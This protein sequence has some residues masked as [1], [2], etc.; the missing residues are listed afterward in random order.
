MVATVWVEQSPKLP[1]NPLLPRT[2]RIRQYNR[3]RI[4]MAED[5]RIRQRRQRRCRPRARQWAQHSPSTATTTP[6]RQRSTP[7]MRTMPVHRSTNS[8]AATMRHR[9]RISIRKHRRHRAHLPPICPRPPTLLRP[10]RPA[11]SQTP[12]SSSSSHLNHTRNHPQLLPPGSTSLLLPVQI[13]IPNTRTLLHPRRCTMLR[14]LRQQHISNTHRHHNT[15]IPP[16]QA[17][18]TP[19]SS[20]GTTPQFRTTS[21]NQEWW[22]RRA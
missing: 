10:A 13:L 4:S 6:N 17:R 19:R 16:S 2:M 20:R 1:T 5:L 12:S 21:R 22:L 9:P 3:P 7:P 8:M 18:L 11:P 14:L 15:D